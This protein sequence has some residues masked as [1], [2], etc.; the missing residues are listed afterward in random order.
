MFI[1]EHYGKQL[2]NYRIIYEKSWT[3]VLNSF[4]EPKP[5][6]TGIV[7]HCNIINMLWKLST[8][9]I[10]VYETKIKISL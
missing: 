9:F 5:T 8:V 3:S 2:F 10:D 7:K 6:T 4:H 1:I